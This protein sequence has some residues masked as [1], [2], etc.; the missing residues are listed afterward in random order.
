M[1][2]SAVFAPSRPLRGTVRVPADKSI[3][4]RALLIGAVSDGVVEVR[5]PL[6]AGDTEATA[7]M[8]TQLGVR[9]EREAGARRV[10]VHGVGLHGLRPSASTLDARNSGT[11]MRLLAGLL[12]GQRGTF[13]IDGDTSLRRRPMARVTEPLEAMGVSVRTAPGGRPPLTITGG[14]VRAVTYDLPVASAQVKSCVL[15]AGLFAEGKTG[16]IER[17]PSRDHTERM[18]GAAGVPIE[19]EALEG[20]AGAD[21]DRGCAGR[22]ID[23]RGPAQP[24]LLTVDVP[25]DASSAAFLVSAVVVVPGS[26]L[27]LEGVGLNPTRLGFFEVLRR[28][29]APVEWHVERESG[30]EPAGR[31]RAAAAGRLAATAVSARE[32]PLLVDELPLVGLVAA[33][34]EGS[35]VV[36][37]AGELR[38][39]E[40]DRLAATVELLVGLGVDIVS[41]DDGFVVRGGSGLRGG[42]VDSRGDHR[43]ALLGAVAG[44][45]ASGPVTVRGFDAADV[46]FPGF[47]D[48]VREVS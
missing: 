3:T 6:W 34:A 8:L 25:G 22:R 2:D 41:T 47:G 16:V 42:A 17:L 39:K 14:E 23:L 33:F 1:S 13:T 37:G 4:Q 11:A 20:E 46:S 43:L 36:G 40:S 28:M 24:H 26:E 45:A 32:V 35:T 12:A 21:G 7:D 18:L 44:L 48:L 38:V 27:V 10:R 31:L 29:G 15:L 5:E 9:I 19:I 30:G